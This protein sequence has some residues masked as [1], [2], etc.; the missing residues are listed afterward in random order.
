[1]LSAVLH[2]N[3]CA[4]HSCSLVFVVVVDLIIPE[5]CL[6]SITPAEVLRSN[7]LVWVFNSLFQGWEMTPMFPMLVPQVPGVDTTEYK[8]GNDDTVTESV[9]C[10]SC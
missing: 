7:V 9:W 3:C 6:V 4:L 10:R 1:M 5:K 8:A 2:L